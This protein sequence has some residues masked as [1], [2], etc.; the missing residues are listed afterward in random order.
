MPVLPESGL[1]AAASPP[2]FA[3]TIELSLEHAVAFAMAKASPRATHP[4]TVFVLI[5]NSSSRVSA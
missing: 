2:L 1:V 5:L 4:Q 3:G